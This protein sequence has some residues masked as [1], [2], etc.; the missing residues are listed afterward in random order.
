MTNPRQGAAGVGRVY[1]TSRP[2][3]EHTVGRGCETEAS[4]RGRNPLQ[5]RPV[6]GAAV[7]CRRGANGKERKLA[8][9][10]DHDH[11]VPCP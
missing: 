8:R 11:D 7:V 3:T 5:S 4:G 1:R 10:A 9:E 2:G 6:A